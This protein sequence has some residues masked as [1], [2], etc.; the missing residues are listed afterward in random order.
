MYI[1]DNK[2]L[3]SEDLFDKQFVCNIDACKGA[4]CWEGDFGA[5][6]EEGEQNI[7]QDIYPSIKSYLTRAGIDAI[8]TQGV[9]IVDDENELS[10]TLIDGGPCAYINYTENGTAYCGIE[11]ANLDGVIDW[12]KP[13]SCH[14]YPIRIK[15]LPD[16]DALNY[17]K[18]DICSDACALGEELK[19]PVYRFLKDALIR[20]YGEDFYVKLEDMANFHEAHKDDAR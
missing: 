5:P 20:K 13:I 7:L 15:K 3:L 12:K 14:L 1:L 6:L 18:W 2:Y 8:E 16:Y 9:A 10:T 11:K 19:V 17:D 4:C